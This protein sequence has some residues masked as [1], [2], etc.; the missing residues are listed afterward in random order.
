MNPEEIIVV[1]D[2]IVE[3]LNG[4]GPF[5]QSFQAERKWRKRTKLA[6]RDETTYVTV[7]PRSDEGSKVSRS[8]W[9][10]D[11][12]ID[13]AVQAFCENDE[14][15]KIDQLVTLA[16]QINGFFEQEE[17][18]PA[19]HKLMTNILQVLFDPKLLDEHRTYTSAV[20][21]GFLSIR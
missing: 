11:M 6:D 5:N 12:V 20:T 1:A 16:R 8:Q 14:D 13:I 3:K 2:A 18:R 19:G 10:H 21:L 17:N 9:Q 4:G 7:V 15:E